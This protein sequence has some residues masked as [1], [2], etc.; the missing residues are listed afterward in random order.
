MRTNIKSLSFKSSNGEDTISAVVYYPDET[1]PRAVLQICHG[2]CEHSGRYHDFMLEMAKHGFVVFAHDHLGH[3]KSVQSEERL[4][5]FAPKNGYKFLI[6][7]AF[8]L[9]QIAGKMFPGKSLFLLGHSM[10]SL[11]A[12][13]YCIKYPQ[14]AAGVILLGTPGPNPLCTIGSVMAQRIIKRDG[15]F[16][17]PPSLQDLTINSMNRR[18][19]PVR[20]MKDW[21]TRDEDC[22]DKTLL[23]PLC[24]FVFTASAFAD[25]YTMNEIANSGKWAQQ[26]PRGLSTLI[27]SGDCDAVGNFGRGVLKVYQRLLQRGVAD[28]NF[29]LYDGARHEL[30]NELNREEVTEDI[31]E[32]IEN[33]I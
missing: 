1:V 7:D 8:L 31:A 22:V 30:L 15:E 29:Q 16:T 12:R 19:V 10:G 25:L 5:Y 3:G 4:G 21:L 14:A 2:M 9:T 26:Y 17:R 6:K 13:L 28:V 33:R 20:T 11:V 24:G 27:L 18:F 32:W 23:D